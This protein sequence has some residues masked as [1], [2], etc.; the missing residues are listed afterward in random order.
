MRCS[1]INRFHSFSLDPV[2]DKSYRDLFM[3]VDTSRP[4]SNHLR[5]EQI[6][7]AL[8]RPGVRQILLR[9]TLHYWYTRD[10]Q[11]SQ[12]FEQ[13]GP[14]AIIC[15]ILRTRSTLTYHGQRPIGFA[16][17]CS[18]STNFSLGIRPQ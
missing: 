2:W 18:G 5:S 12:R 17:A 4:A 16:P 10:S 14:R 6:L 11:E 15:A 3:T 9:S 1:T 8:A 13:S 7:F